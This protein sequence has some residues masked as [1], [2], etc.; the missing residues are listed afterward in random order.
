[1]IYIKHSIRFLL[2]LICAVTAFVQPLNAQ[3]MLHP[4]LNQDA[5]DLAELKRRVTA[6]EEPWKSAFNRLRV[7]TDTPFVA[8]PFAHVLRGP[9]AR[10]NIGGNELSASA[11]MAYNY[12]LVWYLTSDRKYARKAIDILN[13]WSPVLWDFDYNDA[14][15]LAAWTGHVLC[16]AAELLKYTDAGWSQKDID[17]F[18]NMLMTV[19]YPLLR[20]YFPE[21][22]G[23][24]DGAIIHSIMAIAVFTDN[25]PMFDNAVDH[26]L[27][28]PV[29]GSIFKYIYPNG[30]CQ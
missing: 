30:Q 12:A 13:A 21:A 11:E 15:L 22:N 27:H 29:N 8:K 16:N 5:A 23:N 14:K 17:A 4:G 10:P 9:Y 3:K 19:Y 24:W 7:I 2:L 6:G 20:Y 28:G 25:R 1:M 18:G 26:F